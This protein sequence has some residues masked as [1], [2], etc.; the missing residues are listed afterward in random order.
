MKTDST[1]KEAQ[2][3]RLRAAR[4]SAG[5]KKAAD[6]IDKFRWK[7]S[8]YMAHENGQN[9]L[10]AAA[11]VPY[12][13]KFQVEPGWLLTGIGRGP[14]EKKGKKTDVV[15]R[16]EYTEI[17][18]FDAS[19]SM[20]PGALVAEN[21]EPLGYWMVETQWLNGITRSAPNSLAIVRAD[22]DSMTPTLHAG[23]WVL[24]DKAQT[25]LSREGIYAIRVGDD[26]WIKRLSLNL[27]DKLVRIISDNATIPWQDIGED[28][29]H[30]IGR[31]VA[32]VARKVD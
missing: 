29:L 16:Q 2:A 30:V 12:S 25:R 19:F 6:A 23:D 14:G 20:G 15:N 18:R 3:A 21:P 24:I 8:T 22:G 4:E 11:S 27:R 1:T 13:E 32:I 9:G 10:S 31:V 17:G 7:T 26:V 28:D 5:F